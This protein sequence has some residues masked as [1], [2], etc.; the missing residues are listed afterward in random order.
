VRKV[1]EAKVV[2]ESGFGLDHW[3]GD[4]VKQSG[5]HPEVVDLSAR[6]P[7]RLPGADGHSDP[8]WWHDPRNVIAAADEV[9]AALGKAD[10]G[11]ADEYRFNAAAYVTQLRALDQRVADCVAAIPAADRKLVTDHDALGYFAHRYGVDVVGAVIPAQTT[12]AQPSAGDVA[13][14]VRTIRRERVPAVFP[15]S[16]VNAQLARTI[17]QQTGARIGAPL[18]AD[19]LGP[20]GSSGETYLAAEAANADAIVRGLTNDRA[21]CKVK[22]Y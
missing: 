4:V 22:G 18:Y 20:K 14:L 3:V 15:E 21:A 17:A 2:L 12:Q 11:H 19:T 5:G 8:H 10:P 9:A 13:A 1:A 16:S 7:Q 6:L